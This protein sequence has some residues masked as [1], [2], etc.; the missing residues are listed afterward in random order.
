[1]HDNMRLLISES[2]GFSSEALEILR[3]TFEV[4]TADLDKDQII[5]VIDSYDF[6]WVRLR[7]YIDHQVFDAAKRLRAVA[8]NTTGLNHIDLVAAHERGIAIHSLKGQTEFLK[9][10]RATAEHT[11]ALCLALIRKIPQAYAHVLE[12]QWNRNA[13]QGREIHRKTV[14]IIGYGRLGKIVADYFRVFGARVIVT[15]ADI[16]PGTTIDTFET[17]SLETLLRESDIVSLHVNFVPENTKLISAREFSLMK[18]S[19]LFINTARGELVDEAALCEALRSG[20]I[21]GAAVDVVSNEQRRNT[22]Q[23]CLI[24][25]ARHSDNVLITPHIGGNT[26][27]SLAKTEAFLARQLVSHFCQENRKK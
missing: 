15:S 2:D 22:D 27:E 16:A 24:E 17:T 21:S 1:M 13:F 14:G 9:E 5:G 6:L 8:T 4:T 7:S 3:T 25:F 19:A 18:Q 26:A 23:N 11:L 12:G 10:I 20:T